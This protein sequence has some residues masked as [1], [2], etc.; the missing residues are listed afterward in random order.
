MLT[1]SESPKIHKI[2]NR[3]AMF[4][5]IEYLHPESGKLVTRIFDLWLEKEKIGCIRLIQWA[6]TNKVE[7]RIRNS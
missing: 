7:L 4:A 2:R 6:T 3:P 5:K 1:A